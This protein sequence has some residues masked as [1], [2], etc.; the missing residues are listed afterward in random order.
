MTATKRVRVDDIDMAFLDQGQGTP[1]LLVHGFPLDHTM[2]Y[3]VIDHLQGRCRVIAPDLRGY[4]K[5]SLGEVAIQHGIS[6]RRYADDL[7]G[8][9]KAIGLAEPVIYVGFSMG[10]YIGWQ[11]LQAHAERVRALVLCDTR[12]AA[13]SDEARDMRLR[14]ARHVQEWGAQRVAEAMLPKLFAESSIQA[15]LP[16]VVQTAEVI[17]A[18]D[19][20]AIAA[21]QIGMAERPDVTSRLPTIS[22]QTMAIVGKEDQ[23]TTPEE[24]R[25]MAAAMPNA[26]VTIVPGAGHMAP[27][28][29]PEA[30]AEAIA[31]LL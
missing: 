6:M 22:L 5:T 17:S 29:K 3:D 30:V 10:G 19:P 12:A 14:M 16:A 4:G 28:E 7:A 31:A 1:L 8:L 26:A 13:D 24:M 2:W 15:G 23:L 27:V 11:F 9:L 21:A 25:S 20:R 18:T